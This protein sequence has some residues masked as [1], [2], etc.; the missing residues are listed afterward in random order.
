[1]RVRHYVSLPLLTAEY[2]RIVGPLALRRLDGY[3][4]ASGK[5]RRAR[6]LRRARS[7]LR[8]SAAAARGTVGQLATQWRAAPGTYRE[9]FAS[10]RP[11]AVP[12]GIGLAWSK[13][14][15]N[16][17]QTDAE[18]AIFVDAAPTCYPPCST[19]RRHDAPAAAARVVASHFRVMIDG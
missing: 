13:S 12:S 15:Y 18:S 8:I 5:V 17:L 3:D 4:A 14:A 10:S 9:I 16:F 6:A 11:P 1:M 19:Y 2:G 7:T